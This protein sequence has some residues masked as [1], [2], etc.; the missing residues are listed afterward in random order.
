[1]GSAFARQPPTP[2]ST[3]PPMP[4]RCLFRSDAVRSQVDISTMCA[5]THESHSTL[6]TQ[7]HCS[8]ADQHSLTRPD[9]LSGDGWLS[10]P[11][12]ARE[13]PFGTRRRSACASAGRKPPL[14]QPAAADKRFASSC[15]R[16]APQRR[17]ST[18]GAPIARSAHLLAGLFD[19]VRYRRPA[20]AQSRP[21]VRC[22]T[23]SE[24]IGVHW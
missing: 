21:A 11:T 24:W 5:G 13:R 3:P 22:S 17:D 23:V 16:F 4:P 18:R 1:M 15:G 8:G 14:R 9:Y 19:W 7:L 10:K 6:L 2:T 20:R 12:Y